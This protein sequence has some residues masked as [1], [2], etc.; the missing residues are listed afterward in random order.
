MQKIIFEKI[1]KSDKPVANKK[2][3]RGRGTKRGMKGGMER[4]KEERGRIMREWGG[5]REGDLQF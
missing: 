5:Q 1:N 4:G 3:G 2:R